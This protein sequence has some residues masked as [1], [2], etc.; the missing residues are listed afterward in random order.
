MRAKLR[1]PGE[2]LR[3]F[4][5]GLSAICVG[6]AVIFRFE[7]GPPLDPVFFMG[8]ALLFMAPIFHRRAVFRTVEL[9]A[10]PGHV[11]MTSQG[12]LGGKNT[13]QIALRSI[14]GASTARVDEGHVSLALALDSRKRQPVTITFEH[15]VD[16]DAVL[17]ALGIG[18]GGFGVLSWDRG[19]RF[20]HILAAAI[21]VAATFYCLLICILAKARDPFAATLD[22]TSL[23][24]MLVVGAGAFVMLLPLVIA[25]RSISLTPTGLHSFEERVRFTKYTDIST[26]RLENRHFE[27]DVIRRKPGRDDNTIE[28]LRIPFVRVSSL[29]P[30][31][32]ETDIAILLHQIRAASTRA[33]YPEAKPEHVEQVRQ[34][35][36][37]EK[38]E[39]SDH[40]V[41]RLDTLADSW[42][43]SPPRHG[44]AV[45]YRHAL[46]QAVED[47]DSDDLVRTLAARMLARLDPE[48]APPKLRV[49]AAAVRDPLQASRMRMALESEVEP[50]AK[51]IKPISRR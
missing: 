9:T 39:S 43:V 44:E 17:K 2:S 27:I 18:R 47:V 40:W 12:R 15:D 10:R 21:R 19:P 16:L 51:S 34:L 14:T 6:A 11:E 20:I 35:V 22:T 25:K 49:I 48:V 8:A 3:W 5:Y 41:R 26:I 30:G 37:R 28:T 24:T 32:D 29:L 33:R 23:S 46:W 4:F 42:R 45:S 31:L 36:A 50:I 13:S 38:D 7:I 1:E